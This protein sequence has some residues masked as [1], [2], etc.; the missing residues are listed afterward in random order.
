MK[1]I[2]QA[3]ATM[4][5][6]QPLKQNLSVDIAIIGGGIS[7]ILCA[8]LLQQ[9]GF[10][11]TIF[12]ASTICSGQTGKTTAKITAQHGAI[13]ASLIKKYGIA[14]AKHYVDAQFQALNMYRQIIEKQHIDCDFKQVDTFLFT[15]E[16]TEKIKE[17]YDAYQK[18]HL[19][20]RLHQQTELPFDVR[21]ALSLE[22]QAIF[23]PLKFLG[24][25]AEKL[26]IYEN[27]MISAVHDH[28]LYTSEGYEI[29]AKKI[30]FATHY[31]MVNFPGLYWIKMFQNRSYA[32]SI[33]PKNNLKNA[34]LS[35]DQQ[36]FSLRP[37]KEN[38]IIGGYPH[39]TGSQINIDPYEE[40]NNLAREYFQQSQ[41]LQQWSAQDCISLDGLPYI[42]VYSRFKPDWFVMSGYRK[43]GMTTAMAGAMVIVDLISGKENEF[44]QLVTPLRFDIPMKAFIKQTGTAAKN[45]LCHLFN[46]KIKV[47]DLNKNEG[48]IVMN[49]SK[50]MG[51]YRDQQGKLHFCS[52]TCTHLGC[53]LKW[54]PIE[55]TWDCPCHGSRFDIDGHLIDNPSKHH[56]HEKKASK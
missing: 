12:E 27:T 20:G 55:K 21:I 15:Q 49:G 5:S 25:L 51:A 24:F 43:W 37:Y 42:G 1:S 33:Q 4:P 23:N 11:A 54:N 40:L 34:Y 47:E 35:I 36:A 2:F 32:I 52:L 6:F 56:L 29:K 31:P 44:A 10:K 46:A 26:T 50:K 30:V 16:D 48:G 22:K 38:L 3:N 18:L 45:F 7:G 41:T 14:S 9:H 8:Y 53:E 13:Y 39:Q 17:E 28:S 19:R